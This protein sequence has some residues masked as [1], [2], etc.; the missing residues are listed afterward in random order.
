MNEAKYLAKIRENRSY[1][2]QSLVLAELLLKEG[3]YNNAA[4]FINDIAKFAWDNCTGYYVNWELENLL[5]QIGYQIFNDESLAKI[6]KEKHEGLNVLHVAS[7]L[8]NTGGH[9]RFLFH[10]VKTDKE[11]QNKIIVTR[12]SEKNLPHANIELAGLT[13]DDFVFLDDSQNFIGKASQ[14]RNIAQSYDVVILH[15]HP[16]DVIPVMAFSTKDVPPIAFLNHADHIFSIGM[17]I[18]DLVLQIRKASIEVDKVKR[19]P[20]KQFFLPIPIPDDNVQ[21]NYGQIREELGIIKNQ[22]VLFSSG[23]E[24]KYV[25][26]KKYNFFEHVINVLEKNKNTLLYIAGIEANSILGKKYKHDQIVYLGYINAENVRKYETACDIYLEGYPFPS[27]TAM[28]QAAKRHKPLQLMYDPLQV[29]TFLKDS[30]Y[31]FEY[32][33]ESSWEHSLCKLIESTKLRNELAEKQYEYIKKNHTN[34]AWQD[35]LKLL[36][37]EL[38]NETHVVTNNAT[39]TYFETDD[40]LYLASISHDTFIDNIPSK[41]IFN[42]LIIKHFFLVLRRTKYKNYI[43]KIIN[44]K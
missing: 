13:L 20:R 21:L 34:Q 9:T 2:K 32:P 11:N 3:D 28:L 35:K 29:V 40:E 44:R 10:W 18:A 24:Y 36:Y 8:Y 15:I 6:N 30:I 37:E 1:F 12:Q 38:K 31:G 25:P 17:S 39:S 5:N 27:Y 41:H 7:E 33:E 14:L 43:K 4:I 19:N 42:K 26:T 16:Y 22:V 23:T